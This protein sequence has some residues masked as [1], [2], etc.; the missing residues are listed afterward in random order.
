ME[1][2]EEEINEQ[3]SIKIRLKFSLINCEDKYY[4]KI[5][6]Y[7]KDDKLFNTKQIKAKG[8]NS[9]IEFQ[10]EYKCKYY[11]HKNQEVKINIE[12]IKLNQKKNQ[13]QIRQNNELEPKLNLSKIFTSKN[14]IFQIN[15]DQDIHKYKEQLIIKIEN[16]MDD[17]DDDIIFLKRKTFLDYINSGISL[18]SYIII[19]FSDIKLHDINE[20]KEPH[21][22]IIRSLRETLY[23]YTNNN[24]KVLGFGKK[25]N[26]YN[27]IN[28]N[29][30]NN[31]ELFF[32]FGNEE[33]EELTGYHNIR[34]EYI[35]CLSRID[36]DNINESQENNN[37]IIL[38][39]VI[40]KV[41]KDIKKTENNYYIIFILI[42][43]LSEKDY[44]SCIEVLKKACFLPLTFCFIGIGN[45]PEKYDLMKKLCLFQQDDNQ[46]R[47]NV[48][49]VSMKECNND[50]NIIK[51]KCLMNIPEQLCEFYEEYKDKAN[52]P[53]RNSFNLLNNPENIK[54]IIEEKEKDERNKKANM[55]SSL[56]INNF[57][58]NI[59]SVIKEDNNNININVCKSNAI[60]KNKNNITPEDEE[61]LQAEITDIE[62]QLNPPKV[63][64]EEKNENE[65]DNDNN[66]NESDNKEKNIININNNDKK[67]VILFSPMENKIYDVND[68]INIIDCINNNNIINTHKI[69]RPNNNN[70]KIKLGNENN[71]SKQFI[72]INN[73]NNK[74]N[75]QKRDKF[76]LDLNNS[77]ND[78]DKV[79]NTNPLLK[80][81][82]YN[83][84]PGKNKEKNQIKDNDK[85]K[86][87]NKEI[88]KEK[89]IKNKA[90]NRKYNTSISNQSTSDIKFKKKNGNPFN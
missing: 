70:C 10:E 49:F 8:D 13:F 28:Y 9:T 18:K 22:Q 59:C 89:I 48:F 31:Q 41:L 42:Y 47:K 19:D 68:S 20:I 53:L 81:F 45:E 7:Q 58:I 80:K 40:K 37:K 52:A 38:S 57:N 61:K 23:Y 11:F 65:E 86:E 43:Q 39:P 26:D 67:N 77:N 83:K 78:V 34:N 4:Y 32:N 36:Y 63:E 1:L 14:G 75:S 46:F 71:K 54:Y 76:L 44:T 51:E 33:N 6:F 12:K 82:N 30:N 17:N 16:D 21:L 64:E 85:S 88:R 24:Y 73:N 66:D 72:T 25:L 87:I 29:S 62:N 79:N 5:F 60:K 74:I 55:L 2:K 15:I 50:S 56:Q 90:Y 69:D 35:R 3:N 27:S 84:N